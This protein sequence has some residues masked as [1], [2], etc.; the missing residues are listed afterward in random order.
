M[1]WFWLTGWW[2]GN[3]EKKY[4]V[5]F[6]N[7]M[8]CVHR[9]VARVSFTWKVSN[10]P[11]HKLPCRDYWWPVAFFSFRGQRWN[12]AIF[13]IMYVIIVAFENFIK[14]ATAAKY[15]QCLHR[16][17]SVLPISSSSVFTCSSQT[18][19]RFSISTKVQLLAV[20]Q[21]RHETI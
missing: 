21:D 10:F 8:I 2:N 5:K 7:Y 19:S 17:D 3:E 4:N 15:L 16:F 20:V 18:R 13:L 9:V 14:R 12:I 11:T 1:H 6:A